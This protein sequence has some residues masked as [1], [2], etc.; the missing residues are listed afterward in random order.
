MLNG[1][2]NGTYLEHVIAAAA[3]QNYLVAAFVCGK[4]VRIQIGELV[5]QVV[6]AKIEKLRLNLPLCEEISSLQLRF[7]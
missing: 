7:I 1:Q 2:T 3:S 4:Q 5:I 6:A